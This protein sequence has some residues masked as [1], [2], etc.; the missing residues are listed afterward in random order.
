MVTSPVGPPCLPSVTAELIVPLSRASA[1]WPLPRQTHPNPSRPSTSNNALATRQSEWRRPDYL[2]A[3]HTDPTQ[4]QSVGG[5]TCRRQGICY[6]AG[7]SNHQAS[8]WAHWRPSQ[9]HIHGPTPFCE[10]DPRQRQ[11]LFY[12]SAAGFISCQRRR[13]TAMN[14]KAWGGGNEMLFKRGRR[15]ALETAGTFS[16]A[17]T[18]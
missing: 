8:I 5:P 1:F 12:G 2:N 16:G 13:L 11:S 15:S 14:L 7:S 4:R 6:T 10:G 17:S 9:T 3:C 18:A